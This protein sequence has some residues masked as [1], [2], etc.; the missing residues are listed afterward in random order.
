M[1]RWQVGQFLI[2]IGIIG[3]LIFFVT[4]QVNQPNCLYFCS[5]LVVLILGGYAMWT[6]RNPPQPSQRFRFLRKRPEKK[7]EEEMK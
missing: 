1:L 6:G 4:D 5:G 2:L 7:S 3:L